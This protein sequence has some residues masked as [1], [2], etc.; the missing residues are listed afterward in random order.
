[1]EENQIKTNQRNFGKTLKTIAI[2]ICVMGVIASFVGADQTNM[3]N[4]G[5]MEAEFNLGLLFYNLIIVT[6]TT[7][8]LYGFGE[9]VDVNIQQK[10]LLKI[11]IN[12]K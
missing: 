10:D 6:V 11:L 9:L 5:D 3:P 1:M 4:Y 2:V 7:A 12:S 8:L